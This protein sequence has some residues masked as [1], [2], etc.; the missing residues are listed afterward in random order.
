M[1]FDSDQEDEEEEEEE[2]QE[3]VEN[4]VQQMLARVP[5]LPVSSQMFAS[6]RNTETA[7][8]MQ[9]LQSNWT[10]QGQV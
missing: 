6:L 3:D 5:T 10:W 8:N 7:I 2:S 1:D 9:I 4:K